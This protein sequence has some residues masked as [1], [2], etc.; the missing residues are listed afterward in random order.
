[1]GALLITMMFIFISIPM[2][3]KKNRKSKK[4]YEEYVRKTPMLIPGLL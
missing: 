2:M 4:G 3:E 1:M